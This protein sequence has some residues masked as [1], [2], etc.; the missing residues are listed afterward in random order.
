M[1]FTTPQPSAARTITALAAAVGFTIWAGLP[2]STQTGPAA[3]REQGVAAFVRIAEVLQH[4]RCLNCHQPNSPLQG[5]RAKP[6]VPRV[7]RGPDGGGV[8]AMRCSNCHRQT[9]NADSGVPGAPHWQL[10]PASMRWNGLSTKQLCQALKDRKRNGNRSLAALLTH[11]EQDALVMW[12]WQP[13]G[14]R[15]PVP[16]SHTEFVD[17]L[18]VWVNSGGACP[19]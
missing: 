19:G 7:V 18:S 8:S 11:M 2:A 4:P 14:K 1:L 3:T 10:A 17:L 13:G 12:G 6:H 9:N 16:I 15:A 5:D